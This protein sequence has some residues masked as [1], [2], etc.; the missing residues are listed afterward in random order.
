[1]ILLNSPN[2]NMVFVS[3]ANPEDNLF[4]Q[5][6]SLQLAAHGYPVWSDVTRLLGGEDFWNDIQH[7]IA[8]RTVKFVFALSR[9]SNKKD[10]TLQE[11]AYAKEISKKLASQIKDFIITLRMDDIPY[12]EIDIRVNRLNHIPFQDSWAKGFAQLLAKLEEDE[13]PTNPNF[14]PSAVTTWWRTQFSA[15]LGVRNEPEELLSNWFPVVSLPEHIYFH[16]VSR[17]RA[18]KLEVDEQSMPYPAIVESIFLITFAKAEDFDGK[19]GNEMYIA[20]AGEP[21]KLSEIL[22]E[23]KDF[24]KHLFRLFRL[25]W[26]QTLRER[27]LRVYE[28]SSNARAFYFTKGQV[29]NDKIFLTGVDGERTW[30]AM[31]GHSSRT[32]PRTG[33]TS[34]RYWHFGLQ[35]RPMVHPVLAYVLKP[36]VLFTN[37]GVTIW[38]SKKRLAA[39]RRSQCK[40]WW[41]DEWRDRA[42]A[43]ASYLANPDGKIVLKLGSDV[44]VEVASRPLMFKSPVSYTDPQ[45]LRR[46]P[47]EAEPVDDY[48]REMSGEDDPFSDEASG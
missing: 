21:R 29:Q 7:A 42:L 38:A 5:W 6:L 33:I 22:E 18:G 4:A 11:L 20:R 48:G 28:L 3:H 32:N 41:N 8:N 10:G 19:L 14:T 2:R 23:Q 17:R 37:D 46:S 30:R 35:A 44:V 47:E 40:D 24:G 9:A 26:E 13:V 45:M 12:D 43:A 25:A 34:V 1:V 27:K 36:H 15:E 16:N 39:A 31:V